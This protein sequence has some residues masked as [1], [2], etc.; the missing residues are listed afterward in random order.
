MTR[1]RNRLCWVRGSLCTIGFCYAILVGAIFLSRES[2]CFCQS[3]DAEAAAAA[4]LLLGNETSGEQALGVPFYNGDDFEPGTQAA[5]DTY[6]KSTFT[7]E[8]EGFDGV[9]MTLFKTKGFYA[10]D[11]LIDTHCKDSGGTKRRHAHHKDDYDATA[12][13][14]TDNFWNIRFDTKNKTCT[15][16][17]GTATNKNNCYTYA[18]ATFTKKG[19]YLYW[20]N[21]VKFGDASACFEADTTAVDL[22]KAAAKPNDVIYYDQKHATGIVDVDCKGVPKTL[23][24]QWKGSGIYQHTVAAKAVDPLH[25]LFFAFGKDAGYGGADTVPPNN[26]RRPKQP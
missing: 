21:A 19:T 16:K 9:A 12:K 4:A 24:W 8:F 20:L 6:A 15:L 23:E 14:N 25:T 10:T 2:R 7:P 5:T 3:A 18:L 22:K 26:V 13:T 1:P 11:K 17:A